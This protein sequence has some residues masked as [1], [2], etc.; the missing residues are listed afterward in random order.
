MSALDPKRRK[1]DPEPQEFEFPLEADQFIPEAAKVLSESARGSQVAMSRPARVYFLVEAFRQV[2][3]VSV[4]NE[5]GTP[6]PANMVVGLDKT[7]TFVLMIPVAPKTPGSIT[8]YYGSGQ[9]NINLYNLLK[10]MHRQV[11]KGYREYF[12]LAKTPAPVTIG[13]VTAPGLYFRL[14][15][16]SKEP[17]NQLSEAEKQQR[18]EKRQAK[19]N[20][21]GPNTEHN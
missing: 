15:K 5:L 4:D 2:A 10:P 12:D 19:T 11:E 6:R 14:D 16:F 17:I 21:K 1:L 3:E 8:I 7:K 18:R 20:K 13:N 9:P